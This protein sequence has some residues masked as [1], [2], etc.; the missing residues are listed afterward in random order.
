MIKLSGCLNEGIR[1]PTMDPN[2]SPY[3]RLLFQRRDQLNRISPS[4]CL[5]KWMQ[6]TTTLQNGF[7][8]SCH[9]PIPQKIP[10]WEI[11]RDVS[12]LHN[13]DF[14]KKQRKLMLEGKR[15]AECDYCW[16]IEDMGDQYLSDRTIKSGDETF[17]WPHLQDVLKAGATENI[18][19]SYFEV[20]FGNLCNLKCAYCSPDI[21][22]KWME[23]IR[24][25][26]SYR[27]R[28]APL[29]DLNYLKATDRMPIPHSEPNPYVDAFWKWW[30]ELYS[31]VKVFRITG[32]EPL[33]SRNTWRILEEIEKNPRPDLELAVNSNLCV[34]DAL[35]DRLIGFHNRLQGRIKDFQVFTS[36]EATGPQAEYIRFGMNYRTFIDNARRFLRETH[37]TSILNFMVTFNLL[38]VTTFQDFLEEVLAIRKEF[39]H[40]PRRVQMMISYLRWPNLLDVRNLDFES[41]QKFVAELRTFAASAPFIAEELKQIERLT[42]YIINHGV[43]DPNYIDDKTLRNQTDFAIYVSEYD[44]RRNTDFNT[45]FPELKNFREHCDS[46]L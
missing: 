43:T 26:G 36:C 24:T 44:R 40:G 4:L 20:S 33:L 45:V 39:T 22:S 6:S 11:Q 17:G 1:L 31:K 37:P 30:P 28:S 7:T 34:P 2:K 15:P 21:S 32:G 19:P 29:H 25:H 5:A 14:K 10:P 8:H 27:L 12:A 9:H 46:L 35:L 18:V 23:E 41:K 13:T 3:L 42:E 38:S 16:N